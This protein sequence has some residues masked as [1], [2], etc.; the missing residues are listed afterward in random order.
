MDA[1]TLMEWAPVW[2]WAAA[3]AITAVIVK[4]VDLRVLTPAL[5]RRS[6]VADWIDRLVWLAPFPVLGLLG[7]IPGMP[8]AEFVGKGTAASVLYYASAGV[9]AMLLRSRVPVQAPGVAS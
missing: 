4:T 8:V 2:S 1:D 7:A 5:T 9:G 6:R 3:A